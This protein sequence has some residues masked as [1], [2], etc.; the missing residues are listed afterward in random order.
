VREQYCTV[1]DAG[2]FQLLVNTGNGRGDA[3][4]VADGA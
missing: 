3:L 1:V 2:D 4:C